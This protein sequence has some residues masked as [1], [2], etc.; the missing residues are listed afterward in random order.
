MT[1]WPGEEGHGGAGAA[2]G[3]AEVEVVGGGVVVVDGDLGHAEA[4]DVGVEID[5]G[6]GVAGDGG[7]VMEAGDEGSYGGGVCAHVRMIGAWSRGSVDEEAVVVG[8][9][10]G[11][12]GGGEAEGAEGGRGNADV[13]DVAEDVG[14]LSG[15]LGEERGEF[16]L[17]SGEVEGVD[18]RGGALGVEGDDLVMF[19][20]DGVGPRVGVDPVGGLLE[21]V[22][23][24]AVGIGDLGEAGGDGEEEGGEG[25]GL[26]GSAE[27]ADGNEA[28]REEGVEQ[29]D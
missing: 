6:L 19:I 24:G 20:K 17:S 13:G 8:G 22:F 27:A 16:A 21:V 5:V 26:S 1:T 4:E 14:G 11:L 10:G 9:E 7:D 2:E 3:V 28:E 23:V 12:E 18:A 25:E 15:C 29:D